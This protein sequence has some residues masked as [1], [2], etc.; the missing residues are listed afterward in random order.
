MDRPV[1]SSFG[2]SGAEFRPIRG[3]KGSKFGEFG[4]GKM[5]SEVNLGRRVSPVSYRPVGLLDRKTL[6][7]DSKKREKKQSFA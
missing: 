6:V 7:F 3:E 1:F 4:P 5:E 2:G